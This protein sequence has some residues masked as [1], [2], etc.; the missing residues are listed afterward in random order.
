MTLFFLPF[1]RILNQFQRSLL[2]RVDESG[3]ESRSLQRWAKGEGNAQ[4]ARQA[5]KYSL[6]AAV[7]DAR[8]NLYCSYNFIHMCG[9]V[10]VRNNSRTQKLV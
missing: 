5:V 1:L 8:A 4:S 9:A 10:D 7:A 6:I 2:E 3:P